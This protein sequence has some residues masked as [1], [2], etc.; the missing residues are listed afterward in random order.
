MTINYGIA[1]LQTAIKRFPVVKIL[2]V[3]DVMMDEFIWGNVTRISP[4]AAGAGGGC[5]LRNQAIGRGGQC[6]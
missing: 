6:H 1:R 3:G 4:E 5:G 2:V